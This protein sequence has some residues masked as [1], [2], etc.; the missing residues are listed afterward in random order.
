M[1]YPL[2]ITPLTRVQ[3]ESLDARFFRALLPRSGYNRHM[4]C[5]IRYGPAVLG[6][7]G[8]KQLYIEQGALLLQQVYKYLNSPT[9]TIG[10]LLMMTISWTQAF[11][12]ISE[13]FLTE[14]TRP[15]PPVG[16]SI[17]LDL[18]KFLNKIQGK[19]VL[20]TET[21]AKLL[22]QHDRF[23][24][25]IALQQTLWKQRHMLQINA[26]RRYLQAQTLADITNM[27]GTRLQ[28]SVITGGPKTFDQHIRCAA[29]HQKRPGEFAWRT[30]RRFLRTI[31]DAR[32][33]L[34]NPLG[35]WVVEHYSV[36][37]W[38]LFVYDPSRDQLYSHAGGQHYRL[39][40]KFRRGVFLTTFQ[41]EMMTARGYPTS[42][43]CVAG[44]IRPSKNYIETPKEPTQQPELITQLW[45][46]E[47]LQHCTTLATKAIIE[48]HVRRGNV[49]L[50]S[51]GSVTKGGATF[52]FVV[53]TKT[54]QRL[55]KC[56]GPAPGA[57]TSSFRSEAYG[58]LAAVRWLHG[59]LQS[60][61]CS[62]TPTI[63]IYLDN[64]SVIKR[65]RRTIETKFTQPNQ[66]LLSEQ[67]IIDEIKAL[68]TELPITVKFEWIKGHQDDANPRQELSLPAQ[69][70]CEADHEA[71]TFEATEDY[72]WHQ[73]PPLPSTPCQLLIQ[74]RS[75]TGKIKRR[76][77]EA[78]TTTN[79]MV[80][81]QRKFQWSP[82]TIKLIDWDTFSAILQK[83]RDK[84]PTIVKHI[85]D[86]S[87]TGTIAN[88]NNPHLP[89]ECPACNHPHESNNHVILC[90]SQSRARW[91]AQMIQKIREHKK[92][93][94]DPYLIDI[95]QDGLIRFHRTLDTIE[96]TRYPE[97]YSKLIDSQNKIGWDQLYKGRWSTE[98]VRA[99]ERFMQSQVHSGACK[100]ASSWVLSIGRLLL[101]Q[102]LELWKLRNEERHGKDKSQ[103][104]QIRQHRL[105][106]ELHELYTY[107]DQVCPTDR[108]IFHATAQ[109]H[110]S[111]HTS[112]D[113][114][115]NWISTYK[116]SIKASAKQANTLGIQRN[117][118]LFDYP[119]FNPII[120]PLN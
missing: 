46:Q 7:A 45:D 14:V 116:E 76:A 21:T 111:Q 47:L 108:N 100:S 31:S 44:M 119:A 57:F 29:F 82:T 10:R 113:I 93:P 74:Q 51:D 71:S 101:D 48:Q 72:Q 91:R 28:P 92:H 68:A 107:K 50:C 39:H 106:S 78:A 11:L 25:D 38:P 33:V 52:G 15:I 43:M 56:H 110:L 90:P 84:W 30:W 64:K 114:I 18:R 2:P 105:H 8:F 36:R 17:L 26:C 1:S 37:H 65:I 9:T 13:C 32:G 59:I 80:Y 66:R 75:I 6:G 97:R 86:I 85:H 79:L 20:Q 70:N 62:N 102:W 117:R 63:E 12:G 54:G 53:S 23:I 42:V 77:H 34:T 3:C 81:L 22:R 94:S 16:T 5:E 95:L 55:V 87:P 112:L 24:M 99:H 19:L 88:R 115:E 89:H 4:A 49:I 103:E 67:D 69:L 104:D 73:V 98:W 41:G 60:C 83:Y 40:E 61:I 27:S 96:T 109:D 35:P 118:T 58:V 120:Q